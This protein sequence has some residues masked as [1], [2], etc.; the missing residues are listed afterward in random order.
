MRDLLVGL[1]KE[2]EARSVGGSPR[3]R[4]GVVM[5]HTGQ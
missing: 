5:T 4:G 3:I 2:E 1:I